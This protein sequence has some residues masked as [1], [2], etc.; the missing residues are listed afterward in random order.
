MYQ[1]ARDVIS[2]DLGHEIV[3]LDPTSGQMFGLNETG[4]LVWLALPASSVERIAAGLSAHFDV[5]TERARND[6]R[7]LL[8]ALE[9]A[10]LIESQCD[11]GAG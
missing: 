1:A 2:T 9:Q 7:A 3:L 5:T 4:R 6:V 8:R 11:D 10:G